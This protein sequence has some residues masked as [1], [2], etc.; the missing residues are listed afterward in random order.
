[1]Q[2][3]KII[4]HTVMQIFGNFSE[5]MRISALLYL[6]QLAV[7]MYGLNTFGNMANGSWIMQPGAVLY[8]GMFMFVFVITGTWIAVAWHRFVLTGEQVTGILPKFHGAQM[9]SYF[10][11]GFLLGLVIIIPSFVVGM[12]LGM[13]SALF[14]GGEAATSIYIMLAVPFISSLAAMFFFYRL[15]AI[16]PATALGKP[17]PMGESWRATRGSFGAILVIVILLAVVNALTMIM[18]RNGGFD[19]VTVVS[20]VWTAVSGWLQMMLGISLLTTIYGHYVE[21]REL[22]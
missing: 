11:R 4:R 2:G 3:W 18:T 21:G 9:L 7:T 22:V 19:G 8:A 13:A 6:P 16:L 12:I 15:C 5:A 14:G 20:F 17:I 1:M 10:W